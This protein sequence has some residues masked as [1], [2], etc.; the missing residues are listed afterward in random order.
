MRSLAPLA[1]SL[2]LL[3]AR[4]G[5]CPLCVDSVAK[6]SSGTSVWWA[7]GAFLLVPPILGAFVIGAIRREIGPKGP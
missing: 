7:V 3:A 5:A 4:A 6:T 2:L 1:S